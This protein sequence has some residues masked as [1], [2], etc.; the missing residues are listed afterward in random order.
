MTASTVLG[1]R[2]AA[3]AVC[4]H[5]QDA[6]DA[7]VLLQALGLVASPSKTRPVRHRS[8]RPRVGALHPL[9]DLPAQTGLTPA[10]LSWMREHGYLREA[11]HD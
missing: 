8:C 6:A 4:H 5:A 2:S 7:R 9:A 3:L 1:P 11:D 10:D